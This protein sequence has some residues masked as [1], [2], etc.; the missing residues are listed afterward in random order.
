[1]STT[2]TDLYK[3]VLYNDGEGATQGDQNDTQRFGLSR[4]TDQVLRNLAVGASVDPQLSGIDPDPTGPNPNPDPTLWAWTLSGGT[5]FARAGSANNKVKI[6][7][8]T[9]Y[10]MIA[11][12]NGDEAKFL[13]FTFDGTTEMTFTNGDATNPR[14]DIIQMALSWVDGDPQSRDFEDGVTHVVTTTSMNKKRRVQ[15]VLSV[16]TGT[17]AAS[18]HVP[19]PDAGNVILFAMVIPATYAWASAWDVIDSATIPCL[20]DMRMPFGIRGHTVWP[21]EYFYNDAKFSLDTFKR[22]LTCTATDTAYIPCKQGGVAGRLIGFQLQSPNGSGADPVDI[23]RQHWAH[24][25]ASPTTVVLHANVLVVS[26]GN[27]LTGTT[28]GEGTV[29]P[30][31]ENISPSVGPTVIAN[32]NG[33]GPP[34]WTNGMRS[35]K[36]VMQYTRPWLFDGLALRFVTS[37][38]G[39]QLGP[40]RWFIAEGI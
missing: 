30:S 12:S 27:D 16:K 20:Y 36:G 5:G 2:L 34:V 15:C 14:V 18:P 8:G 11:S 23:I 35:P 7:I 37:T 40:V 31:F 4:L 32:T 22:L 6:S 24:A 38:T 39:A 21:V 1:M 17:P 26:L 29:G 13:P 9:V 19:D 25:G 28:I 10:Q 3:T 33:Q